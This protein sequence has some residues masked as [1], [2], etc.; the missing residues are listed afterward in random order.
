MHIHMPKALHSLREAMGEIA[1]V[2]VGIVIA[3]ALEQGVEQLHWASEVGKARA[4]LHAEMAHDNRSFAFRVAAEPCIDRRLDALEGVIEATARDEAVPH[5]GR[6]IP[7]IGNALND[8]IW[9]DHRAAQTLTHFKDEELD[10]LGVY[11]LQVGSIRGFLG[12][13]VQAWGVLKVLQ[14]DPARLGPVDIA[15]LRV[16]IQHARFDNFIISGIAKD[17]LDA[18]KALGAPARPADAARVAEVCAPLPTTGA[19]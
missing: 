7:D 4:S 17:E 8:N 5:L 18:S 16:A 1:I 14:G 19:P 6:V 12:E 3:I 11:Y 13:E 15:G 9:Q 2:V 10:G